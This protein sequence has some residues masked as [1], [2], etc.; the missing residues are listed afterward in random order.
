MYPGV[1]RHGDFAQLT[2]SGGLIVLGRSDATLNPG[3]VRIGTADIYRIVEAVPE[4]DDSVVIGQNWQDDVRVILFVKMAP[5]AE[6]TDAVRQRIA[7]TIRAEVSPRH[8]PARIV[9][10]PDIPYTRNMK[11]VELAVKRV[12]ENRPVSNREALA[13]PDSLDFFRD[14]PELRS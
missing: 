4:V 7:G 5:G 6:L 10:V 12:V 14:L 1:W 9:A 2:E 11:K 13:N 3:G 8:V